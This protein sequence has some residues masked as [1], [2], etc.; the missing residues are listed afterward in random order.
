MEG[1]D[2]EV[3]E[4]IGRQLKTQGDAIQNVITAVTQL[5]T[6]AESAWKGPD[7]TKFKSDWDGIHK[8]ALIR[9]KTEVDQLGTTATTNATQQRQT[10]AH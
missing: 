1:M 5:V 6:Q 7:A 4:G 9:V 8:P 2:P 10:S 3:V